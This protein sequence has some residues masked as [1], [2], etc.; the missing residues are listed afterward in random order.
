MEPVFHSRHTRKKGNSAKTNLI[1]SVVVHVIILAG[2]GY[3]AAH[4][5]LLGDKMRE[6]SVSLLDKNKQPDKPKDDKPKE[7]VKKVDAAKLVQ[8]KTAEATAQKL[9]PPPPPPA[10][11]DPGNAPPPPPPAMDTI[12]LP[13][14]SEGIVTSDPVISYKTFV[15]GQLRSK[16]QRPAEMVADMS[17]TDFVAEVDLHLDGYGKIL[18]YD[19]L[20]GSGNERWDASV[21]QVLGATPSLNRSPPKGFPDKVTVRFDVVEEKEVPLGQ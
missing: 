13:D 9:P 4:E 10:A 7:E 19:W 5:G 11:V 1:I 16:W 18:S 2:A 15:E 17:D 6:L 20:R 8:E 14:I 3:W 21:K 12:S